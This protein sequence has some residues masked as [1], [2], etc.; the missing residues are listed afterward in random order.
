MSMIWYNGENLK[1]FQDA[2]KCTGVHV[3][4][5]Q[6][7]ALGSR[8]P[9]SLPFPPGESDGVRVSEKAGI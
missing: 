3:P 6:A 7:D 8:L 1:F 5:A 2:Y 4:L 9:V